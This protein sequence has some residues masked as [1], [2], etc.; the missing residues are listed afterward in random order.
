MTKIIYSLKVMLK[1]TEMGFIPLVTMPNPKNNKFNCWIYAVTDE[2]KV[3][4]D[5]ILGGM[6]RGSR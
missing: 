6:S 4:L 3:A 5:G 2:F 1:L